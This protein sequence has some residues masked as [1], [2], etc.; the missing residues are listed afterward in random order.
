VLQQAGQ[1]DVTDELLACW[2]TDVKRQN[3]PIF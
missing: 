3:D 1:L 2:A